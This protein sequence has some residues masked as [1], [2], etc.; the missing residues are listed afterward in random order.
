M[1]MIR[2]RKR[3]NQG[4]TIFEVMIAVALFAIIVTPIM[5]TFVNSIKVNEKARKVM[6]ATDVAQTIMEGFSG[7]TYQQV[8]KG[9]D[10]SITGFDFTTGTGN[11]ALAFSSINKNYFNHG[12]TVYLDESYFPAMISYDRTQPH[13]YSITDTAYA[14]ISYDKL[15]SSKAVAELR[16]AIASETPKMPYEDNPDD[17]DHPYEIDDVKT[18]ATVDKRIYYG[19]SPDKY[20]A[21]PDFGEVPKLAYMVYNRVQ[22]DRYFF[23]VVVTFTP[24]SVDEGKDAKGNDWLD[25][26]G[27]IKVDDYFSYQVT[28]YVYEYMY[29]GNDPVTGD[30]Y[31]F[32]ESSGEWPS[33][34]EDSYFEGTPLAIMESGI[35]YQ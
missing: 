1:K 2:R 12:H 15:V 20:T 16:T 18:S 9:L 22:K 32:N 25:D 4:L 17:A 13:G 11:G 5:R 19:G 24:E 14:G 6:V 31:G 35:Q 28:V 27:D 8:W 7:K 23:D 33:R 30:S 3:I 10:T 26:L 34:F 21:V 29:V